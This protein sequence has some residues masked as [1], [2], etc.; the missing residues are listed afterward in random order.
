MGR[1]RRFMPSTLSADF[2]LLSEATKKDYT[3]SCKKFHDHWLARMLVR[4]NRTLLE[5]CLP[6]LIGH[7]VDDLSRL[8]FIERQALSGGSL[9]VPVREAVTAESGKL[10][11]VNILHVT[12][13]AQMF[14]ESTKR[15]RL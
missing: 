8:F 6:S 4:L 15:R 11:Q 5:L 13:L 7:A 2:D 1:S 12:A 9:L 14:N 3:A 10:H